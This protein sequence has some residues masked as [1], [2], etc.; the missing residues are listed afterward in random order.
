MT[1][2]NTHTVVDRM[3]AQLAERRRTRL[4]RHTAYLV[5]AQ[6][7]LSDEQA[8]RVVSPGFERQPLAIGS[9]AAA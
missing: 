6:A 1:S 5:L 2:L 7:I 8:D 9:V 4:R 3:V